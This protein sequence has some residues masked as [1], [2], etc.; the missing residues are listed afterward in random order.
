MQKITWAILFLFCFACV[1]AQI[2][3]VESKRL[4]GTKQGWAG[5]ID[6]NLNYIKNTKEIW[7]FGNRIGLEY[8]AGKNR[9]LILNDV[10]IISA[11]GSDLVNRG[12][13]HLRHNYQWNL[14]SP[15]TLESF[16]QIQYNSVQKI[17]FRNLTGGGIRFKVLGNDSVNLNIG[18]AAMY[19]VE[20]LTDK[21]REYN[22]RGSNYVSFNWQ[23]SSRVGIKTIW[24][25][26][27]KW[28]D[29]A[30]FRI[31]GESALTMS[32]TTKLS[33]LT[34]F[35]LLY[36]SRPPS[37][38]PNSILQLKNGLRLKIG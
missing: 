1:Q 20:E 32:I 10:S 11:A 29:F 38:I 19:E 28:N 4:N 34:I 21:T 7:Q 17:T 27:P 18:V 36:D 2:I 15:F 25:Y 35:D 9:Y 13:L 12:Y 8:L 3:N 37:E 5:N 22:F 31:S 6:L 33:F 14:E 30:D 16:E 23:L 26:Q 24:Y